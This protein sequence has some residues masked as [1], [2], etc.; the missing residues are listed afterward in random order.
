MRHIAA[1]VDELLSEKK[2]MLRFRAALLNA[3]RHEIARA[4]PR[5]RSNRPASESYEGLLPARAIDTDEKY[6]VLAAIHDAVCHGRRFISPWSEKCRGDYRLMLQVFCGMKREVTRL[7]TADAGRINEILTAVELDLRTHGLLPTGATQ[8]AE[9][10]PLK[11]FGPADWFKCQHG[12]VQVRLS[13][14]ANAGRVKTMPAPKGQIDSQGR[15]VRLLYHVQDALKHCSPKHI[16][17]STRRKLGG[18]TLV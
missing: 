5:W 4:R 14:A 13:E 16:K 1:R 18:G 11:E 6:T 9:N 17:D 10:P 15:K 8:N 12:I 2:V 3:L 7:A